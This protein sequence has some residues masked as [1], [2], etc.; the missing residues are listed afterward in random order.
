MHCAEKL[1]L[2]KTPND[3]A[4]SARDLTRP[5]PNLD[6]PG[7]T[8]APVLPRRESPTPAVI[9]N[10]AR[11]QNLA[12]HPLM[13]SHLPSTPLLLLVNSLSDSS[14]MSPP[15]D[16]SLLTYVIA[17]A[18]ARINAQL[19]ARKGI[20]H[21]DVPPVRSSSVTS[22]NASPAPGAAP[23]NGEVY[24]SDGDYI[25]DIEVND[26]RNRYLLTKG[27]TQKMV[28]TPWLST[29]PSSA[30]CHGLRDAFVRDSLAYSKHDSSH[31]HTLFCIC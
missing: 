23:I 3:A 20:Q 8:D 1:H 31:R 25:K 13:P 26:L 6:D 18:A 10:A 4:R 22:N 28:I 30:P 5:N 7:S 24:I 2:W 15:T 27:S 16:C 9:A 17:A 12:M 21:V 11:S 29:D 19:Q 14:F